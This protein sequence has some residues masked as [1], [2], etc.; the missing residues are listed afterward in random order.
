M[1]SKQQ[2]S[3]TLKD[4]KVFN[5]NNETFE[6]DYKNSLLHSYIEFLQLIMTLNLYIIS[7]NEDYKISV[8]VH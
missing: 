7:D 8:D 4:L 2:H 5:I 1:Q 6:S 3:I